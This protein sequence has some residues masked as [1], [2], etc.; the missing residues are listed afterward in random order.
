MV[1]QSDE[2][3]AVR[4]RLA[5]MWSAVAGGWAQHA[6]YAD[7]R[8]AQS[9]QRMLELASV[10]AGDRVLELACGPGGL[11]LAAAERVGP[12]GEV[13]LT[14][15]R[16]GDDRDR[17]RARRRAGPAATSSAR[18]P[19]PRAHRRARRRLRRRAVPRGPHVR[20]RARRARSAEIRRVLRPGGRVVVAVWGARERNPWLGLRHGRRQRADRGAGAAARHPRPVR[21]RRRRRAAPPPRR[22]RPGRRARRA[23]CR[24]RCGARRS[25]SGG[26]GRRR[27][28]A[29][30]RRSSRRC[31]RR[32]CRRCASVPATAVRA[33]ETVVGRA[34]PPGR[35][36]DRRGPARLAPGAPPHRHDLA[37]GRLAVGDARVQRAHAQVEAPRLAL[38][39]L[40]DDGVEAPA[41]LVDL[42][43]VAGARC[44]SSCAVG[45]R[46]AGGVGSSVVW[47]MVARS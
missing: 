6:D 47:L 5:G 31:P 35:D 8:G 39:E 37:D 12:G 34:G 23:S 30:C 22:R 43:D 29:R 19:R 32:A 11:G 20:A 10:G 21:A 28:P 2:R 15:R 42:D 27:W 17:R 40:D 26:G 18:A 7:A 45:A 41:L 25:T 36:A 24:C 1:E 33:Y 3:D 38:L 9:A 13:V 46:A 16:R 44:P 14:R 4:A